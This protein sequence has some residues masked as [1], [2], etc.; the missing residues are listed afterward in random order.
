VE[1]SKVIDDAVFVS[2]SEMTVFQFCVW[3]HSDVK[4]CNELLAILRHAAFDPISIRSANAES[5]QKKMD[6]LNK[7]VIQ[8]A[9][10]RATATVGFR[11]LAGG[12]PARQ[13]HT[14][15]DFTLY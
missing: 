9:K 2:S 13:I 12:F 10:K 14:A 4:A 7:Q 6:V 5:W 11:R 8:Y 3:H 15:T 1:I